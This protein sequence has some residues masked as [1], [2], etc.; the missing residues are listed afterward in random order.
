[1]TD[2]C[3][4]CLFYGNYP[5]SF[6]LSRLVLRRRTVKIAIASTELIIFVLKGLGK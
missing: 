1:M 6:P 2:L 4:R 5:A 3:S